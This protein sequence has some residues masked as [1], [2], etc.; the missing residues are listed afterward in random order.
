MKAF[1]GFTPTQAPFLGKSVRE[2]VTLLRNWG[3]N[4]IFGGYENPA[5]VEEI[6]AQGMKIYAEFACFQGK[7][8]WESIPESRPTLAD[9]SLLEP[10]DWYHGLNPSVPRLREQLLARLATLLE[11]H[12]IDGLWLDFIRWPC[13]WESSSP[14]LRQSSFDDATL[15]RFAEQMQLDEAAVNAWRA[16]RAPHL[17]YTNQWINWRKRQITSWVAAARRVVEEIRP[18]TT[19]GLFA[20]PWRQDDFQ[21][22]IETII[23]QDF[24]ALA[25]YI[26]IFSPMTYHLMCGQETSW[27]AAVA[28]EM[29]T[30]TA[31]P[32]CPIIQ[33]VAQPTALATADYQAA[34]ATAHSAADGAII[35]TLAGLLGNE[36]LSATQ[37]FWRDGVR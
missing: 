10:I 13:R 28:Q 16:Q 22:A 34:L 35:F 11:T 37:A 20:I 6:H 27:I 30:L 8:W 19:L 14:H 18:G 32:I 9:G 17:D 24:R 26:D 1:Y 15:R 25:P 21:G 12:A 36:K 5:F 7:P 4:A 31:K 2:Q 29:A 23:G 3:A 33:S